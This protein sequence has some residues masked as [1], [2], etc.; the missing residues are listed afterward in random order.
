MKWIL[1][2]LNRPFFCVNRILFW[3]R[4]SSNG[5][6]HIS[7]A[8]GSHD[9]FSHI[10]AH[11]M[12]HMGSQKAFRPTSSKWIP[13]HNWSV[14]HSPFALRSCSLT[15]TRKTLSKK[16]LLHFMP[17]HAIIAGLGD[18]FR[19]CGEER[20]QMNRGW[21]Q[22]GDA[23]QIENGPRRWSPSRSDD[24]THVTGV[25]PLT[26]DHELW[27]RRSL[28]CSEYRWITEEKWR[29]LQD[30]NQPWVDK[31]VE[32]RWILWAFVGDWTLLIAITSLGCPLNFAT[33]LTALVINYW[34]HLRM[35]PWNAVFI[36]EGVEFYILQ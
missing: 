15:L 31:V 20:S 3:S 25:A 5:N 35:N 8:L 36:S 7:L 30:Q 22:F 19:A 9:E 6:L 17:F 12:R 32:Y 27:C 1:A 33:C 23:R 29:L 21:T 14:V 34:W 4:A 26:P 2:Q 16:N 11:T 13:L 18:T 10:S 24:V 28:G